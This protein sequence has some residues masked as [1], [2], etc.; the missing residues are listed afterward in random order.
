MSVS[1][2]ERFAGVEDEF[3]ITDAE[4]RGV[5]IEELVLRSKRFFFSEDS[6][7][8]ILKEGLPQESGGGRIWT[9]YGGT[10]YHDYDVNGSLVEATTPLVRLSDGVSVLVDNVITQRAQLL[11]LCGECK[12]T[13]VSTHVNLSLDPLF[14]GDDLCRFEVL[15]PSDEFVNVPTQK[16]GADIALLATHTLSPV[17]A[18]LLFNRCP[19]KGALYR[20]RKNRR[21]ELCLPYVTE[22]EQ[23]RAGFA[24]WFAAVDYFTGLIK[25][26][27]GNY[28]NW[29]KRYKSPEYYRTLLSQLPVVVRD[30]SYQRPSYVLGFQVSLSQEANV[31]ENGSKA[32]IST[33]RG[34]MTVLELGKIYLEL[35]SQNILRFGGIAVLSLIDDYLNLR[36]LAT[37]DLDGVPRFFSL[38]SGF[39]EATTGKSVRSFLNGHRVIEPATVHLR[40]LESPCRTLNLYSRRIPMRLFRNL[41]VKLDWNHITLEVV[42]ENEY[43]VTQRLLEVPLDEVEDYLRAEDYC[44]TPYIFLA[45]I[46]RWTKA[47]N[48]VP[49]PRALFAYGTL[50]SPERN[51]RRF[52][53]LVIGVQRA[54]AYGEAYDFG[55]FPV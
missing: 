15:V 45:E 35:L 18:Y 42:E 41:G 47:V 27:L 7:V 34:E 9:W 24:F 44:G 36:R 32:V 39:T 31:M 23:M 22:P 30:V 4:G 11:E 43:E 12:I 51:E 28:L 54:H 19:Q 29:Q 2:N 55:D 40:F 52:G 20:P 50:M 13:G 49:N 14:A 6:H 48:T 10:L 38:R 17:L 25:A 37:V 5:L 16:L 33:N 53:A 26:D 8:P 3:R 1:K 21:M 46:A